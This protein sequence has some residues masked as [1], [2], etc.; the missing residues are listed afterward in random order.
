MILAALDRTAEIAPAIRPLGYEPFEE[1]RFLQWKRVVQAGVLT[2]AFG[3]MALWPDYGMLLFGA[4]TAVCFFVPGLCY[5]RQ[6]QRSRAES[7]S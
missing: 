5:Y 2:G 7:P 4:V 3:F 6:R 1:A